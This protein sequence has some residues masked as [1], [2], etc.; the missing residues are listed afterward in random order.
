M[1]RPRA[2][3]DATPTR[4]RILCAA[5]AVFA[6]AGPEATLAEI[7]LRAGIRRPSLL[8]HFETKDVLYEAVVRQ[9]FAILGQ[10]L[11]RAMGASGP[12]RE[13]LAALTRAYTAFLG[14]HPDHARIV[15]RAMLERV[16]PGVEIVREQV[17][18][19]LE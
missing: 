6:D 10:E 13:R 18:P 14:Q 1:G 11:G 9:T 3:E 16:G 17:A 8:Y 5:A 15:A 4:D 12:F 19:L 2:D 7:A